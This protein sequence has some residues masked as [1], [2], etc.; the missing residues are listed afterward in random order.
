MEGPLMLPIPRLRLSR[1]ANASAA[2]VAG[3]SRD[4][5]LQ[6]FPSDLADSDVGDRNEDGLPTPMMNTRVPLAD[7]NENP[8][9][10]LRALLARTPASSKSTPV[11]QPP[12]SNY[13]ENESDFEPPSAVAD[14]GP[15]FA[16]ESLKDIFSRALRDP[17]NTP[18][19][20]SNR[21]RRNSIDASEVEASP[22]VERER[23]KFKA[24]RRSLSD[25]EFEI[26]SKSSQHSNVSLN[27]LKDLD[28]DLSSDSMYQQSLPDEDSNDTAT[29]L[30][31]INPNTT[32]TPPAAT[33][34][35]QQSLLM[36][37][38]SQYP[39][40]S[41]LM[42]Q[43]SEMQ[44]AFE[45]FDSYEAASSSQGP[46]QERLAE[47]EKERNIER[48]REWNRP[49]PKAS[50]PSS[51]LG[52]NSPNA[53]ERSRTRSLIQM[54]S[55]GRQS[56]SRRLQ[57]QHSLTDS[58]RAGSPAGSLSGSHHGNDEPEPEIIHERE[59]NWNA[60]RPKWTQ[61]STRPISPLSQSPSARLRAESSKASG[62]TKG[63]FVHRDYWSPSP[64]GKPASRISGSIKLSTIPVRSP[65]KSRPSDPPEPQPQETPP[66][67]PPNTN[68]L[69]E[70]STENDQLEAGDTSPDQTP[71]MKTIPP[72]VPEILEH[73]PK[74][75][76][77]RSPRHLA[78]NNESRLRKALSPVET[79]AASK[80]ALSQS[81]DE[82]LLQ[83]PL[84]P[85]SPPR[86]QP[87]PDSFLV[88][89]QSFR[90]T[91]LEFQTPS[92]PK[93]LPDLPGP[94]TSED[95]SNDETPIRALRPDLTAIQTPRPPGG[96]AATPAPPQNPHPK[97]SSS[98]ISDVSEE[99]PSRR[100]RRTPIRDL[101]A[102]LTALK[103]P[104]PP[105]AW[106]STPAP[107]PMQSSTGTRPFSGNTDDESSYSG[108][109]TPVASLSQASSLP[110]QTPGAPGA[111]IATPV[112]RKSILKV[113][114]DTNGGAPATDSS[115][116]PL[117][118][119][120]NASIRTDTSFNAQGSSLGTL[121]HE[122]GT[123]A[124][125]PRTPEPS[126][127]VSPARRKSSGIRVLDAFGMVVTKEETK[128]NALVNA[129]PRNKSGIRVVDAMGR[130]VDGGDEPSQELA[131][132]LEGHSIALNHS[133]ALVR[134]RQGLADLASGL[135]DMDSSSKE[136]WIDYHRLKE[137]NDASKAARAARKQLGQAL[138][139][140]DNNLMSKLGP[141]RASMKQSGSLVNI[142]L[143]TTRPGT[144]RLSMHSS[145]GPSWFS[146]PDTFRREGFKASSRQLWDIL[147]ILVW[148]WQQ[149]IWETLGDATAPSS[150]WPPT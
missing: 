16:R 54:D 98:S 149:I 76:P 82:N 88:T 123:V 116:D 95:D 14:N 94:P 46:D 9:A 41:N 91:K 33:S 25:E 126:S 49:V 10:R 137:L 42:E 68:L 139:S 146:I 142:H 96:W 115:R 19:K 23:A 36:S 38:N 109:A 133:E 86:S 43:D 74:R 144:H 131:E 104:K 70:D 7:P 148:D 13:S 85:G 90:T 34:T 31:D 50:R 66:I 122:N 138:S 87:A 17:G 135:E 27:Q 58:S 112:A 78:D 35:P 39:L 40:Q 108:L 20:A 105:G 134:V 3:P 63:E 29:F 117:E 145:S 150:S 120:T 81:A 102:N 103:T 26:P 125:R 24:K 59:R 140:N 28:L 1:T 64:V 111:W 119:V 2:P 8:A 110:T 84:P 143:Y 69:H 79:S 83:E 30:R 37:M 141:L 75:S 89:P 44:R 18:Q 5:L 80:A 118:D 71:T 45:G 22:R 73:S 127:P 48:E 52:L 113:R 114:F 51:S 53:I 57:R 6:N 56:P 55:P 107:P 15:S 132:D 93:N 61:H 128:P 100:F 147:S 77:A 32:D 101:G 121:K 129:T 12:P 99:Q 92:P 11:P 136:A 67:P 106:A 21:P 62:T 124:P 97:P 65:K 72:P 60:P 47:A 130:E 4:R